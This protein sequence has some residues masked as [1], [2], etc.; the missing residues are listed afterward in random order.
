MVEE[1]L[2][3][4]ERLQVH[5]LYDVSQNEFTAECSDL[6]KQH[7]LGEVKWAKYYAIIVDYSYIEQA[8]FLL[9]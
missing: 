1:S 9:R 7:V 5:Y 8:T 3:K 6:V 2:K 4:G